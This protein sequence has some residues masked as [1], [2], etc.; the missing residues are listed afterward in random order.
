VTPYESVVSITQRA[1][2]FSFGRLQP[3]RSRPAALRLGA[4]QGGIGDKAYGGAQPFIGPKL[5]LAG[6]LGR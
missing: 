3:L 4:P 5:K 1:F 2:S 6:R